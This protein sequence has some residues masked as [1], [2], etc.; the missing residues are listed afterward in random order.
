[1]K[2]LNL[3]VA[4]LALFACV[5]SNAEPWVDTSNTFL[6]ANI[7]LLADKGVIT[8]PVTTFPLMWHDIAKDISQ[9]YLFK[10]D[11]PTQQALLYVRHQLRLAK[12]N[13]KTLSLDLAAKDK[14][15]TSFGEDFRTKNNAKI[16]TTYIGDSIAAKISTTYSVSAE[17]NEDKLRFDGSYGAFFWGNWVF[18]AGMQDRWWGPGIDSSLSVTNNA[19]PMPALALSRKSAEPVTIPWTEFSIPWTVT[20]FM[21]QMDDKRVVKDALLW[22][23][24][25]NF[26]P[27]QNWEI[28]ITRLAQWAGKDRPGNFSTFI[29][30]LK[31]LD[32]C[33]G[34][35]PTVDECAAGKEPGN[36]LAGYDL[37]W[38]T[39][40]FNH[41]V[42]V[43]ATM[44]AEDGDRKGGLSIF[45]EERYQA[46]IET[47]ITAFNYHWK[48][49][50][51][52]TDTYALCKDG[53]NGDG[54]SSIGDCYYEHHIYQ[55]G[56]R[57]HGKTVGSLYDNDATSLVMGA[58][59]QSASNTQF[60]FKAR[61]LQLNKD[62]HDKAIDNKLIGNPLTPIAENMLML[63]AKVQHSYRNWR[64]TFGTE[65]SRSR[66]NNNKSD[67]NNS[68]LFIKLEYNQ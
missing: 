4:V 6:R 24:R 63:S 31:G 36:Q 26:K 58:I 8:T 43:S 7:Q 50:L 21:G 52:G 3:T 44:I 46:N 16:S 30:V 11:K 64:L 57:Y 47:Q 32:N 65:L 62:N 41:P 39:T 2:K 17:E 38:S 12:H 10:L 15:F 5:T 49:Y 25:L 56:M 34:N 23:F 42:A 48:L 28:G 55:T 66:F 29:D 13:Q 40:L 20:T 68:N 14:R 59:S 37:R 45:G 27:A 22:G 60:E 51:E 54:T 1:M 9:A 53:H 18:S 61:W 67:D 19:R 33:G 35:G